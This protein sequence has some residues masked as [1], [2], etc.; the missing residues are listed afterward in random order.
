MAAALKEETFSST[1]KEEASTTAPPS[2]KTSEEALADGWVETTDPSTGKVYYYNE[3]S[4]ESAWEKPVKKVDEP[5][6]EIVADAPSVVSSVE[7]SSLRKDSITSDPTINSTEPQPLPEG[8]TET[9][10][11]NSGAVYYYNE[12]SGETTWDRPEKEDNM[13][14]KVQPETAPAN[15]ARAVQQEVRPRPAHAIASFGFGGRL[16]VMIPQVAASLSGVPSKNETK[17][18]RRGPV[19]IHRL[20]DVVPRD[21]EYSIPSPSDEMKSPDSPLINLNEEKVLSYLQDRSSNLDSLLW[22]VINIAAQNRGRLRNDKKVKNAIVELLLA[23]KGE[24]KSISD[25]IAS[26]A[27]ASPSSSDLAEVQDLLLRGQREDAVSEALSAKNYALALIIASMCD[28]TTYH[29]AARRFADEALPVGSPLHTATLYFT[30]NLE[31]PRDE[32]LVDP[33][34]HGG[35]WCDDGMSEEKLVSGWREQ[36]AGILR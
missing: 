36:L 32:E 29:I 18:M 7:E 27:I 12:V 9:T 19:V 11:P 35:Y 4:G 8:W 3:V 14:P 22:N 13:M 2:E 20:K 28:R 26:P 25:S 6:Q 17:A 5:A 24:A 31:V 34:F 16:C 1:V 10:D 23:N 21:H 33:M 30:D 15:T